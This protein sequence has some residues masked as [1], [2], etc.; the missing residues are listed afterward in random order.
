MKKNLLFLLVSALCAFSCGKNQ[1]I[2][3]EPPKENPASGFFSVFERDLLSTSSVIMNNELIKNLTHLQRMD[4]GGSHYYPLEREAL[5]KMIQ[6]LSSYSYA[7][8]FLLNMSGTVIYTMY[9]NR[10]LSK[11]AESFPKSF[12]ILFHHA[13]NGEPWILDVSEYPEIAGE[14]KLLFAVPVKRGAETEGVLIAAMTAADIAKTLKLNCRVI[15]GSGT[16]RLSGRQ[17]DLFTVLQGFMFPQEEQQ[18]K[19]METP[20]GK[21]LLSPL[22]YRNLQWIFVEK[23]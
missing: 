8:C 17:D 20:E 10:I 7:D 23:N 9:D 12:S 19:L 18:P 1:I 3:I 13:K 16:V 14:P 15:D 5:T 2:V 21:F 11:H 4:S 22:K 6:S